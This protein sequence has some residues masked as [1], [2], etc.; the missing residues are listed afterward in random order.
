[1]CDYS[2]GGLK[3]RLAVDSEELITYRFSTRSMGL[4]SPAELETAKAA[5]ECARGGFWHRVKM[6]FDPTLTPEPP[7]V[8][9]PPGANLILKSVPADLQAEWG[10]GG[11]ESVF[12]VQTS[13][14]VNRYRDALQFRNGRQ[15]LL[16]DLREG[17]RLVLISLGGD[18][19]SEEEHSLWVSMRMQ[20][21]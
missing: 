6:F 16:Q 7:A 17:M 20:L 19:A 8:C 3:N 15:V 12:F 2:L 5:E 21:R 1:M 14:D 10:V 11:E 13:A 4:A 18:A 9:V